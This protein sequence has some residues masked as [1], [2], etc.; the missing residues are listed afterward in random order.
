MMTMLTR[1]LFLLIPA[2]FILV[3]IREYRKQ[4]QLSEDT[5]SKDWE[6]K[7]KNFQLDQELKA[8]EK[9][10]EKLKNKLDRKNDEG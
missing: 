10:I 8:K 1:L 6:Q 4:K 5:W 3:F 7:K 9:E 2:L